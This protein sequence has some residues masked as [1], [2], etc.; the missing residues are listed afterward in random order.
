MSTIE[1]M[2][3][4]ARYKN[5]IENIKDVIWEVDLHAVFTFISPSIKGMVG[6]EAGE[7]IGRSILEFLTPESRSF[8]SGQ[9]SRPATDQAVLDQNRSLL[10]DVEFVCKDGQAIWCEVSVKPVYKGDTLSCYIGVS[11]DISDKKM[12]ETKLKEMLEG[13]TH[14]NEQLED[15]VTYDLL[16]G[17]YN[18]RKF[19]YF[20]GQ[21]IEKSEKYGSPFSITIFDIDN[22]KQ[23][24]D[25]NGHNK[26]DRVLQ[27][28]TV[29]VKYTL[30]ATDKLFRWGGDEFIALF[31]DVDLKNAH[32][33]V[34]KIRETIQSYQFDVAGKNVT[35]SL[36]VGAYIPGETPEQYVARVD[37]A[38]LR[39]KTS[40][41]NIVE[42][43]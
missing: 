43:G 24:N 23:I 1:N 9:L 20:M 26:G 30:R 2:D 7:M 18:R 21:E 34:N 35:V 6:Y 25:I 38:L 36:G 31:P 40:G 16:T 4:Y 41:K 5:L 13:Q 42:Q 19:E 14:I 11:R 39:A 15:I 37:R 22:F 12:Y 17:A 10:Y 3:E 28:I 8:L 29:L 27:D 32:K 33:V